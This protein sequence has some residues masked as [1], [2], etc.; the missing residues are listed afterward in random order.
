MSD[1]APTEADSGAASSG[2]ATAIVES[3]A[4]SSADGSV[5][6]EAS[7]SS[8]PSQSEPGP[9][10][11]GRFKQV[12]DRYNALK[13]AEGY[14][15][16]RVS[17]QQALFDWLDRDP[18]GAFKYI[19]DYLSRAGAIKRNNG[20]GNTGNVPD[21]TGPDIVIPETGQRF[22]SADAHERSL[23]H[24]IKAAEDRISQRLG[25][26]EQSLTINRAR[27]EA[28]NMLAEAE[29][30]PYY[31]DHEGDILREMQAD[32]RLSL[33]GAYRRVVLPKVR[34]L[35]RQAILAEMKQK[36]EAST[37]N[38]GAVTTTD[39]RELSK[40]SFSDLFRREMAKRGGKI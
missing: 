17:Q 31:K 5:Q 21:H 26:I 7:S 28:Q 24:A 40:L 11:Y 39:K 18:E 2:S 36:P 27:A 30:W 16:D 20:A 22:Y 33:E 6:P 4:S 15:A 37:I 9:I 35:E 8:Q 13:W 25:P 19:E 29:T 23:Q 3:S 1:L 32:K 12:N 38:P 10:P 14:D 34:Q